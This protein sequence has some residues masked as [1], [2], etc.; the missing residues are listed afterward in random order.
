MYNAHSYLKTDK[1]QIYKNT[2]VGRIGYILIW[3]LFEGRH[4]KLD[5]GTKIDVEMNVFGWEWDFSM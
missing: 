2:C 5:Y 4:I 3:F 1:I